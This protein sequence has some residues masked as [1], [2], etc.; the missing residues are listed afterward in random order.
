LNNE[1][2][3]KDTYEDGWVFTGDEAY[4]R[5]DGVIFITD[6][7]KELIKTK[8]MQV[9]PA[10]LEGLLLTHEDIA[11]A[12]VVG[13]KDEYSGELPRAFVVLTQSAASRLGS[14]KDKL[15]KTSCG[16]PGLCKSKDC[17]IQAS[18]WRCRIYRCYSQESIGQIASTY[19]ARQGKCKG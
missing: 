14:D 3:T 9:A 10:E 1:K 4:V 11:D 15:K 12:C 18:H 7:I 8:G 16:Y 17:E 19:L 6:R 5:E 2:A 13:I